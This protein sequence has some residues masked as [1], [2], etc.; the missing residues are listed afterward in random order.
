MPGSDHYGLFAPYEQSVV[1]ATGRLTDAGT[2]GPLV[3]SA[4]TG[5]RSGGPDRGET[6]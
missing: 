4:G 1:I 5:R 3:A 6:P 2:V